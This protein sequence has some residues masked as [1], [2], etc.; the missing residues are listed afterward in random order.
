MNPNVEAQILMNTPVTKA[1]DYIF[2][3][4][5]GILGGEEDGD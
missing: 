4:T 2:S 3:F 5:M 1:F